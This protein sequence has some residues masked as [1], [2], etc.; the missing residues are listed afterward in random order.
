MKGR[1]RK[2]NY[3]EKVRN[4]EEMRYAYKVEGREKETVQKKIEK[5][6]KKRI[7]VVEGSEKIKFN[8]IQIFQ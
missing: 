6:K 8:Q 3:I 5:R 1:E 2:K 4:K 7:K